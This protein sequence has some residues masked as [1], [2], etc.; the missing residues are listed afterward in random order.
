MHPFVLRRGLML[1]GCAPFVMY[2]SNNSLS[3]YQEKREKRK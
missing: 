3:V 2:C 1:K